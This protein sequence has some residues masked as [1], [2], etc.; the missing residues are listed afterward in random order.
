MVV[1][2]PWW[3]VASSTGLLP[4]NQQHPVRLFS[5]SLFLVAIKLATLAD[6]L[7]RRTTH[8][9]KRT[10]TTQVAPE[11]PAGRVWYSYVHGFKLSSLST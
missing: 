10:Q 5:L 9:L 6:S 11:Y 8:L 4:F 2:T 1:F 7:D 3:Y